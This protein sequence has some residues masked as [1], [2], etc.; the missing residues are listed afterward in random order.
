MRWL[1]IDRFLEF[2]SGS[3]AS[4]VKNISIVEEQMEDYMTGFP[5]FPAA[6]IIEG[7]AQ[8]GGLLIAEHGGFRE[9]VVLAKVSKAVFHRPALA[10]DQLVYTARVEEFQGD[11]AI[12]SCVSRLGDQIQAEADLV[13]AHLNQPR[14]EGVDLFRPDELMLMLRT[15]RLYEVGRKPDGTEL[16]IPDHL[17]AA[18]QAALVE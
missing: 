9:R 3:C 12:C 1:W 16:E 10:G 8:T 11:G 2:E 14:F 7:M 6:L 18:E 4:A 17:L 15:F 5:A 13:F